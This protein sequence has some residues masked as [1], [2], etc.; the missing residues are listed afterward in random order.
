MLLIMVWCPFHELPMHKIEIIPLFPFIPRFNPLLFSNP[1]SVAVRNGGIV[2]GFCPF[3]GYNGRQKGRHLTVHFFSRKKYCC[4]LGSYAVII[5]ATAR[6]SQ[7]ILEADA[8]FVR[9]VA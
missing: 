4:M 2:V 9:A 6:F 8:P 5:R 1:F 7:L 3:R